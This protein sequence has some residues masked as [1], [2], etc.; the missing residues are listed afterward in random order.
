[1]SYNLRSRKKVKTSDNEDNNNKESDNSSEELSEDETIYDSEEAENY[2]T[3]LDI[4][5]N[6]ASVN[7]TYQHS[8]YERMDSQFIDSFNNGKSEVEKQGYKNKLKTIRA[9][10]IEGY[11]KLENIIDSVIPDEKKAE[12][13]VLYDHMKQFEYFQDEFIFMN[14][15]IKK[16]IEY[17]N[18]TKS[19]FVD[20]EKELMT[21]IKTASICEGNREKLMQKLFSLQKCDTNEK[22]DILSY[23]EYGLKIINKSNPSIV[24]NIVNNYSTLA[25]NIK[26]NLDG[27]LFGQD[28]A[29]EEIIDNVI[30]R[31]IN[32]D[33]GNISVFLGAPGVG[34]THTA[35]NLA[36]MLGYKFYQISLGAIN[37]AYSITG[38]LSTYVGSRPG[39]IYNAISDMGCDNGI[40]FLDEFDKIF[41]TVRTN[42]NSSLENVFL[43]ILDPAQ[44]STFKDNHLSSLNID[45]SKIWFIISVNDLDHIRGP[46]KDRLRPIISFENYTV[47]NKIS[48]LKKFI[49]PDTMKTYKIDPSSIHI[50]D[51]VYKLLSETVENDGGIR[52]VKNKCELLF[53]RLN[54]LILTNEYKPSYF[55]TLKHT[56]DGKYIIN[57][58]VVKKLTDYKKEKVEKF[59][60]FYS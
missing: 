18:D 44:N 53:K 10:Q 30:C 39:E 51:N 43:N 20:D 29:K 60:S 36:K 59:M 31:M 23:I 3:L 8:H 41:D 11:V 14:N 33:I 38:S 52:E 17:Y 5:Y 55:I 19:I 48:I 9:I 16:T 13:V 22:H 4:A 46:I 25:I 35:R 27:I 2:S 50:E 49:I 37:D 56:I 6:A 21:K 1:M 58:D 28:K 45:L 40:I 7:N 54:T 24:L 47:E 57:S 42:T 26:Q 12:L 15:K 32:P 34:K